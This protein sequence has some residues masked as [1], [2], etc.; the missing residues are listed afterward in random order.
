ME[1]ATSVTVVIPFVGS[2]D[3]PPG[4]C[5]RSLGSRCRTTRVALRWSIYGPSDG[6]DVRHW[7]GMV[8]P[9]PRGPVSHLA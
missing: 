5:V 3:R 4:A 8:M 1:A 2:G 9:A 7:L 6:R